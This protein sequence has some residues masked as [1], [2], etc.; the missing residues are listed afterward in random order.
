[1]IL[2]K[3]GTPPDSLVAYRQEFNAYFD[4]CNKND[5]R[6]KLLEEQG[7]LCAYCM[8]RI[9]KETMK[10]EHW[11]PEERLTDKE[12]LDY[13]NMLGC[14][15]GHI[16]GTSGKSD[17][18]DAKKGN[19][20]ISIDPRRVEHIDQIEYSSK[21]GRIH[22]DNEVLQEDIDKVLN[23]NGP[24]YLKV[25]RKAALDGVRT[26]LSQKAKDGNWKVNVLKK[27]LQEYE[28]ADASGQKREYAGI[29]IWYL[30]KKL[31]GAKA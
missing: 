21:D 7:H 6:D 29:V 14:C 17:T 24:H 10:I 22:S 9:D 28:N 19:Q 13:N 23:L 27:M 8:Q 11:Y 25:N 31:N 2:I 18:C 16:V 20:L 5:I 26:V 12:C 4:G 3:K 1:M 30:R 15:P